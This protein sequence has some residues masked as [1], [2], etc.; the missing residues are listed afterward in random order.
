[1]HKDLQKKFLDFHQAIKLDFDDKAALQEKRDLLLKELKEWLDK[2]AEEK[3]TE[4]ITFHSFNQGSYAMGT[5]IKPLDG[6]DYDIDVAIV[7]HFARGAYTP[8]EVKT[9]IYLALNK[10]NRTVLY[11]RPCMRTQYH[12]NGEESMHVDFASYSGADWNEDQKS[13]LARG[14]PHDK[15]SQF[16][17]NSEPKALLNIFNGKYS[18]D[19][20]RQFIRVIRDKK[21]WKDVNFSSIGTNRP[22]GIGITACAMNWFSPTKDWVDG[23]WEY[24]D[25]KALRRLVRSMLD[26]FQAYWSEEKETFVRRLKV[27]LPVPPGND[28]FEK[29]TD[30]QM[31]DFENKLKRLLDALDKA[32]DEEDLKKACKILRDEFGDDFPVPETSEA[33]S[34]GAA[35]TAGTL[36]LGST[37]T[38][39][40]TPVANVGGS[41]GKLKH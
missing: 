8:M 21:R 24:N 19:D 23:K 4:K 37:S 39:Y 9:W 17:E 33:K 3:K 5:G 12:K 15:S 2:Q 32:L 20:H 38:N 1:M 27:Y 6:E 14:V 13:Y 25:C 41:H 35:Q 11:K 18:G 16:Y 40:K 34:I 7:Y 28:L 10:G 26:N 36:V 29:M 31:K 22:I 30:A